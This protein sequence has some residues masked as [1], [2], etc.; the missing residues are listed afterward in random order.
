MYDPNVGMP[1]KMPLPRPRVIQVGTVSEEF[2]IVTKSFCEVL[3]I[4]N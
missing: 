3:H 1:R 2:S 4:P